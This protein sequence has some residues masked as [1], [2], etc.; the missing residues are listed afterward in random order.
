MG[1][2]FWGLAGGPGWLV[3]TIREEMVRLRQQ[4]AA[5]DPHEDSI[6]GEAYLSRACDGCQICTVLR[7]I[8]VQLGQEIF[9]GLVGSIRR[10]L[11][12]VMLLHCREI[13]RPIGM[14]PE[15]IVDGP[16]LPS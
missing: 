4:P 11:L 3:S 10:H 2:S 14:Q 12:R 13:K 5:R 9:P 15:H 16:A 7:N 1:L 8:G 6:G